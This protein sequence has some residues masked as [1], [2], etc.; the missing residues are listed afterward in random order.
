VVTDVC[1][2]VLSNPLRSSALYHFNFV[3]VLFWTLCSIYFSIVVTSQGLTVRS[4]LE[5]KF[6]DMS[7]IQSPPKVSGHS[8]KSYKMN[9]ISMN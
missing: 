4:V 6:S 3:D 5:T 9:E 1:K 8:R 2:I 7:F